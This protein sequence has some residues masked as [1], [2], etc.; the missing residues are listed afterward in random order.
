MISGDMQRLRVV[1]LQQYVVK[2]MPNPSS[3]IMFEQ[4]TTSFIVSAAPTS[5][6]SIVDCAVS[7]RSPT[8]Q[9]TEAFERKSKYEHVDMP[10]SGLLTHFASENAVNLKPSWLYV[11]AKSVV[12]AR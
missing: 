2:Y 4:N 9:L 8:L 11:M 10:L 12:P 6:A 1:D 5:S 3:L 7:P